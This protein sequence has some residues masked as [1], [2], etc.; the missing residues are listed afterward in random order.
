MQHD[1]MAVDVVVEPFAEFVDRAFE[2]VVLEGNHTAAAVADEVMVVFP[3]RIQRLVARRPVADIDS[4]DEP[5]VGQKIEHPIDTRDPNRP[6]TISEFVKDLLRRQATVLLGEK[7]DD[8]RSSPTRP[9]S[10]MTH[11]GER[12]RTPLLPLRSH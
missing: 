11:F 4:V 6:L 12:V 1:I 2:A 5:H 10:R 3:A 7:A 9:V 8:R